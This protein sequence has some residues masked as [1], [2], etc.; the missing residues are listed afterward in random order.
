[1]VRA[2]LE[3]LFVCSKSAPKRDS[4]SKKPADENGR[5]HPHAE[6]SG[7]QRFRTI[8]HK[9]PT[10]GV[11]QDD[12]F[13][14]RA[15]LNQAL[16]T[17]K[18]QSKLKTV[19][20]SETQIA[21][22]LVTDIRNAR[23]RLVDCQALDKWIS[24]WQ[25]NE[26]RRSESKRGKLIQHQ[27]GSTT[28]LDKSRR[29]HRRSAQGRALSDRALLSAKYSKRRD[30]LIRKALE[31]VRPSVASQTEIQRH[32]QMNEIWEPLST[33]LPE[34]DHGQCASEFAETTLFSPLSADMTTPREAVALNSFRARS[35]ESHTA[36]TK[37][38]KTEWDRSLSC[39]IQYSQH[40]L[41]TPSQAKMTIE[42]TRS[43]NTIPRNT[44][45]RLVY[46]NR[47]PGSQSHNQEPSLP[48]LRLEDLK[49]YTLTS[50]TTSHVCD[51]KAKPEDQTS[52]TFVLS[53]ASEFLH[54][55]S[56][57]QFAFKHRPRPGIA[58]GRQRQIS[59]SS[60]QRTPAGLESKA[61][62]ASAEKLDEPPQ[63][64][65]VSE[66]YENEEIADVNET[67]SKG[68]MRSNFTEPPGSEMDL[69]MQY[70]PMNEEIHLQNQSFVQ[71]EPP[72]G[73]VK[74][75]LDSIV[76]PKHPHK[77]TFFHKTSRR[78]LKRP[79]R[80]E[81]NRKASAPPDSLIVNNNAQS[82]EASVFKQATPSQRS[83]VTAHSDT[84]LLAQLDPKRVQFWNDVLQD[85]EDV[86][87]SK[88]LEEMHSITD[89]RI[90]AIEQRTRTRIRL[91]ETVVYTVHGLPCM[92]LRI[93]AYEVTDI[94]RALVQL[95][96]CFPRLYRQILFTERFYGSAA[97]GLAHRFPTTNEFFFTM[98]ESTAAGQPS[99]ST[100][101]RV[102]PVIEE[103]RK[104][105]RS[106]KS[107]G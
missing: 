90:F 92:E 84:I 49:S 89:R 18:H 20:L 16:N 5:V 70:I 87:L 63:N 105:K 6:R 76:Q 55:T 48:M 62:G 73:F 22:N 7:S 59:P 8:P 21:S 38:D 61:D 103:A 1:M 14:L 58:T 95:E 3:T 71:S 107:F 41:Y 91:N 24:N 12:L 17:S 44:D 2:F 30:E 65:K 34:L 29:T 77:S 27:S 25:E 80:V 32:K 51:G 47:Q 4:T 53:A 28:Q 54:S 79:E 66:I 72:R 67:I 64:K 52:D 40:E 36:Q 83:T 39:H 85:C 86:R 68:S 45:K 13:S 99:V 82:K 97:P 15:I 10:T 56:D 33:D 81:P 19:C 11:P 106:H 37:I 50:S 101:R 94:Q 98:N 104:L 96:M 60:E 75:P 31:T 26:F 57:E 69:E 46:S 100:V 74:E 43:W 23:S 35:T 42:G 88:L 93:L 9:Q 78:K 102:I